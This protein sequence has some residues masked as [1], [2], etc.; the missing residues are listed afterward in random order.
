MMRNLNPLVCA[1]LASC[2][3]TTLHIDLLAHTS[4]HT[5]TYTHTHTYP[6][7]NV[8][9]SNKHTQT[10]VHIHMCTD[11]PHTHAHTHTQNKRAQVAKHKEKLQSQDV[12][13]A[14]KRWFE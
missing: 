10:P 2:Y 8:I 5:H 3:T 11:T 12:L 9:H 1:L 13:Q 6:H 14:A 4:I 7:T